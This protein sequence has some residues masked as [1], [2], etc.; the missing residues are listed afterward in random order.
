MELIKWANKN[1]YTLKLNP[2]EATIL[3]GLLRE[4]TDIHT[5]GEAEFISANLASIKVTIE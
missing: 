3:K 5:Y 4:A 2:T 1:G